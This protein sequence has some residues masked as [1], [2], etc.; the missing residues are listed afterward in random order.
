MQEAIPEGNPR[1]EKNALE[2][3]LFSGKYTNL[4]EIFTKPFEGYKQKLDSFHSEVE[5][6]PDDEFILEEYDPERLFLEF[7]DAVESHFDNDVKGYL[8]LQ[9]ILLDN[10]N[11]LVD[12]LEQ[13]LPEEQEVFLQSLLSYECYRMGI[14]LNEV[15]V[16]EL[17]GSE[18][19]ALEDVIES[20]L[21]ILEGVKKLEALEPLAIGLS[22]YYLEDFD[23]LSR[24]INEIYCYFLE[25]DRGINSHEELW[26]VIQDVWVNRYPH[27][28]KFLREYEEMN[29][30]NIFSEF[31]NYDQKNV[32]R[33][34]LLYDYNNKYTKLKEYMLLHEAGITAVEYIN[35][36]APLEDWIVSYSKI[37]QCVKDI[38]L[39]RK[40]N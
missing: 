34:W 18:E 11:S 33:G 28:D 10:S 36:A 15:I 20:Y 2:D 40:L 21:S 38:E 8:H 1:N 3:F 37:S 6:L 13:D 30:I 16:V 26:V 29:G 9:R 19:Y 4:R 27:I 31:L 7:V 17:F 23:K 14:F 24:D 5:D 22:K 12:F 35:P 25:S 32:L 39:G